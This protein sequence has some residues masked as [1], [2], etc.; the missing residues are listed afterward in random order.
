MDTNKIEKV[1][2]TKIAQDIMKLIRKHGDE[3]KELE[4]DLF[5]LI[6]VVESEQRKADDIKELAFILANKI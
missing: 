6:K 4:K 1:S 5:E 3:N 2:Y